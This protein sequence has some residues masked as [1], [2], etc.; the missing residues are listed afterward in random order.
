MARNV[1]MATLV[2]MLSWL[3]NR[4]VDNNKVVV[5]VNKT[6]GARQ[7]VVLVMAEKL[8]AGAV[9]TEVNEVPPAPCYPSWPCSGYNWRLTRGR[10]RRAG[11]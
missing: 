8:V 1:V 9:Q 4:V 2:L 7:L 3:A 6:L 11:V 10:Q 5:V